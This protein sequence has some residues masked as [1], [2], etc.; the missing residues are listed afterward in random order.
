[1]SYLS[2]PE[3]AA[4]IGVTDRRVRAMIADGLLAAERIGGRWLLPDTQ[5]D[6]VAAAPRKPGR[7][8]SSAHAW[9]LLAIA[10]DRATPWLAGPDR[11]R[12]STTLASTSIE[13]LAPALRRRAELRRWFVHPGLLADFMADGRTVATG[14]SATSRLSYNGPTHLYVRAST[15]DALRSEYRPITDATDANAGIRAVHGVWPFAE[16]E[17]V[18]WPIVVAIDLLDEQSDVRARRVAHEIL[19]GSHA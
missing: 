11:R 17:S 18:A 8:Y 6:R 14:L 12:L 3:A 13:D 16:G 2:V 9:G 4:I 5:V 1:M 19:E 15:I 10:A 7:P